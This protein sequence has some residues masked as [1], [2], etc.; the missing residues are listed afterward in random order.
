MRL[1]FSRDGLRMALLNAERYA[2][3]NVQ[4]RVKA[5]KVKVRGGGGG[6][7]G[8]AGAG[9]LPV[10]CRCCAGAD[11]AGRIPRH[12]AACPALLR[13]APPPAAAIP[14]RHRPAS[15]PTPTPT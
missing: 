10:F 8:G 15:D 6:G 12:L 3:R 1:P 14:A 5:G 11:C 13:T 9:L 7:G 4:R 2:E